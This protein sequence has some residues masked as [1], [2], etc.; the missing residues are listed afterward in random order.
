MGLPGSPVEH[1]SK[2][3]WSAR[4]WSFRS[5]NSESKL[6]DFREDFVRKRFSSLAKLRKKVS[7]WPLPLISIRPRFSTLKASLKRRRSLVLLLIWI[8]PGMLVL[9]ILLATLTVSQKSCHRILSALMTPG[10]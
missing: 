3:S 2:L 1:E 10:L 4:S 9:S 6:K 8:L 5:M 7:W